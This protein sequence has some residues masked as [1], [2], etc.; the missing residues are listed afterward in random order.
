MGVLVMGRC[1]KVGAAQLARSL[2][3]PAGVTCILASLT[4]MGSPVCREPSHDSY[5]RCVSPAA[6]VK[7]VGCVA[8]GTSPG[9][10]HPLRERLTGPTPVGPDSPFIIRTAA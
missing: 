1:R 2:L 6:C 8:P 9:G 4:C 5:T 3:Q 7:E 10:P